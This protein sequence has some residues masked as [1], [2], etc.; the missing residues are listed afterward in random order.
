MDPDFK[1]E[2]VSDNNSED[3]VMLSYA[4][5]CDTIKPVLGDTKIPF[6]VK[7]I[8][9][10]MPELHEVPNLTVQTSAVS[11]F[12]QVSPATMAEAQTKDSVLGLVIQYVCRGKNK[13]LSH[14]KN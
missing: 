12:D 6:V 10:N 1:M 13:G 8:S 2:S 11:V 5:I 14:F 4:I 9:V 3:P 7:E